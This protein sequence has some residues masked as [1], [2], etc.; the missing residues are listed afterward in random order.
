[1]TKY[2]F[3]GNLNAKITSVPPFPGKERHMLRAQIAR[4]SH[5]T[6]LCPAGLYQV[7]DE[8]KE[9]KPADEAPG[10]ETAALNSADAWC[11]YYPAILS[12]KGRCT[13]DPPLED[14]DPAAEADPVIDRFRALGEDTK[15]VQ[16]SEEVGYS[17]VVKVCGDTQ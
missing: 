6:K 4:I 7:D 17:W 13:Y 12:N 3:T 1:M 9:I 5:A 16:I 14:G 8:T 15:V 2:Q 11:H 10:L